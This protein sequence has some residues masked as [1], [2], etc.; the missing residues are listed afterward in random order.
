MLKF[1]IS[2][3]LFRANQITY[4]LR[5]PIIT[6]FSKNSK[7]FKNI[8]WLFF[9]RTIRIFG[10]LFIGV[11]IARYL[12]PEF[13]GV[14][15]YVI[16]YTALFS[17]LAKLGL[18][19]IVVREIVKRPDQK[20]L[21]LGTAFA[22]KFIG[23][24]FLL[25]TV[26][27]TTL[28]FKDHNLFYFV[29]IISLGYV[30]QSFDVIDLFFQSH[31]QSKFTV[32]ARNCAFVVVSSL[33]VILILKNFALIYFVWMA[34]FEIFLTSILLLFFYIRNHQ[35]ILCWKFDLNI[36]KELIKYSWPL[37]AGILFVDIYMRI[38]QV[39]IGTLLDNVQLGIYS[40]AVNLSRFWYFIPVAI[41]QSVFPRFVQLKD[42]DN[43]RYY[44]NLIRLYSVMFWL[45]AIAG[46]TT[47]IWGDEIIYFLYGHEYESSFSALVF[48]I[49]AGIF[50]AQSLARSIWIVSENMQKYRL[51]IQSITMVGNVIANAFLIPIWGIAG[52]AAATL[53]SQ[54]IPT[55]GLT[56]LLKPMRESTL[57]LF[58]AINPIYIFKD[59]S[60]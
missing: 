1:M 56:L 40:A 44:N 21:I 8:V 15:N 43:N 36:A 58:K 2:K 42:K 46:I 6:D 59:Y 25:A 22:L 32:L 54:A 4:Y 17:F 51:A 33:R 50:V 19:Q 20:D 12:G 48:N 23:S 11:W 13:Y 57:S 7:I 60:I 55:W 24:L 53:L 5:N 3:E 37:M 39:M 47:L 34:F 30:F 18:D 9:D 29:L 28:I 14:L 26:V 41:V 52:A 31:I 27:S 45:G 10:G 38:D 35:K 16:A 49:W